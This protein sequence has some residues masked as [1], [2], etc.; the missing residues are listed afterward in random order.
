M[1]RSL[2][3]VLSCAAAIVA[4]DVLFRTS[5]LSQI[6]PIILTPA[7]QATVTPPVQLSWEGPA[8]MRVFL[9][10]VGEARRDLGVHESP[11]DIGADAL[12]RD[13]GYEVTI[14]TP[15][16]GRWIRAQR[17]FQVHTAPSAPP[18]PTP[19]RVV[20]LTENKDLVRALEAART[21]RDRARG[22]TKFLSE[23]NAALRNESARLAQQ[24]EAVYKAQEDDAEHTAEVERRLAQLGEENHALADENA[25]LRLRL[26]S[27][28]ACTVW[29]YYSN[30]QAETSPLPRRTLLVS[31]ARGQVFR[32]QGVCELVRRTDPNA[33]SICFCV[34]NSWGG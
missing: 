4:G 23:E 18:A 19:E 12:P 21:A 31:D 28:V 20:R 8:S 5:L 14:E 9:A 16:F 2:A 15:R 33:A 25:A 10:N 30:V 26:G 29:G 32:A 3:V 13:G 17:W 6:R 22:R 11:F 27:V 1:L 24:L 34:G 7:S